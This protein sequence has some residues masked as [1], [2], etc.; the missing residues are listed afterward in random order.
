MN[1]L[2]LNRLRYLRSPRVWLAGPVTLIV[3]VLIMAAMSLWL[4]KGHAGID[5]LVVPL[6]LFP[7]ILAAVFFYVVLEVKPKRLYWVML[8]LF[9]VNGG[10]VAASIK[11]LLS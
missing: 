10:L 5:H 11:G 3:A 6:V 8:L 7:F 9:L 4:P 2:K 1:Q